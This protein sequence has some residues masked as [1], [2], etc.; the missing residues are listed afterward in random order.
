MTASR[1]VTARRAPTWAKP[2]SAT[3]IALYR[4]T[5]G[6]IGHWLGAQR[7]L[8]LTTT[9]PACRARNRSPTS[10]WRAHWRW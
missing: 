8:L 7:A 4:A 10:R 1:V 5:G 9:G 3:H 6:V 2:L